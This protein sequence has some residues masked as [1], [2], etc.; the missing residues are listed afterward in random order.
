MKRLREGR[1]DG[2]D[3]AWNYLA[4]PEEATKSTGKGWIQKVWE[5]HRIS[6]VQFLLGR[7]VTLLHAHMCTE[8]AQPRSPRHNSYIIGCLNHWHCSILINYLTAYIS[9]LRHLVNGLQQGMSN[10]ILQLDRFTNFLAGDT[11]NIIA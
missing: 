3:L 11:C 8:V 1:I 2:R 5:A 6:D 4:N 7:R 9:L 10:P